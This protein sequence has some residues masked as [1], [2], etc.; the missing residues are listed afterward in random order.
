MLNPFLYNIHNIWDIQL[1]HHISNYLQQINNSDLL[2]ITTRI[3]LQQLQNNLWSPTSILHHPKPTIDGPNRHSLNFKITQLLFH[4]E[5]T[6]S[7]NSNLTWPYTISNGGQ[8]LESILSQHPKYSTFKK[9]LR[10]SNIM[11]LEQLC[12]AD[13]STLLD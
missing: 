4:L 13:N 11:Y 9:Q 12:T 10:Q 6:I 2:G 7:V 1:Q 5:L 8:S 3:R